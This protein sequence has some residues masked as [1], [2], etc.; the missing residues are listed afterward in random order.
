M[1]PRHMT[2]D[3]YRAAIA[4]T[5]FGNAIDPFGFGYGNQALD[6]ISGNKSVH[7]ADLRDRL[8]DEDPTTSTI[9]ATGGVLSGSAPLD[10]ALKGA[11]KALG[12]GVA[13]SRALGAAERAVPRAAG[14]IGV[15]A[16]D[17]PERISPKARWGGA[18][19]DR[20]VGMGRQ[21]NPLDAGRLGARSA[22]RAAA[23]E[24]GEHQAYREIA[25][26]NKRRIQELEA[27]PYRTASERKEL[28]D[29]KKAQQELEDWR[30]TIPNPPERIAAGGSS[31]S[32]V[33]SLMPQEK[34]TVR[35]DLMAAANRLDRRLPGRLPNIGESA[36]GYGVA[37][38]LV[39][40]GVGLGPMESNF[41]YQYMNGPLPSEIDAD[42]S[43]MPRQRPRR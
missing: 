5:V 33:S 43:R 3:E 27:K 42:Q 40:D 7:A 23:E 15:P 9:A 38:G 8:Y 37:G 22:P 16:A 36:A 10:L 4:A 28:A 12:L 17:V 41:P 11:G 2:D 29:L 30:Q 39:A 20:G 34:S 32:P 26:F 14:D 6:Y 21:A 13:G 18:A 19:E 35:Q 1:P 25:S 24:G 31:G